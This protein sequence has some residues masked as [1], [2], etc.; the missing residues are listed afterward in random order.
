M[1]WRALNLRRPLSYGHSLPEVAVDDGDTVLH[2]SLGTLSG[3]NWHPE[4]C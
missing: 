4:L 3:S 2:L 1:R